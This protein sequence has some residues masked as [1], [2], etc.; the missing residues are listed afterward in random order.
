MG[1]NTS[2]ARPSVRPSISCSTEKVTGLPIFR[3][4]GMQY[5]DTRR[6]SVVQLAGNTIFVQLHVVTMANTAISRSH[7]C[8]IYYIQCFSEKGT[9]FSVTQSKTTHLNEFLATPPEKNPNSKYVMHSCV[10][11]Q[12]GF[13]DLTGSHETTSRG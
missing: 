4:P 6:R 3:T 11:I 9:L 12:Q 2:L 8:N 7:I 13:A 1:R 5:C 10:L